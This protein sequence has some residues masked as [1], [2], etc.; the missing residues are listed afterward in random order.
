MLDGFLHCPAIRTRGLVEYANQNR[1]RNKQIVLHREMLP[2]M[3]YEYLVVAL[4]PHGGDR[5]IE[6]VLNGLGAEGWCLLPVALSGNRVVMERAV[7]VERACVPA[8]A[9]NA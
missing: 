2:Q 9:V 5:Q 4:S 6:D 1:F 3:K 8:G 7:R